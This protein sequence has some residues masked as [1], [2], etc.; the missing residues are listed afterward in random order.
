MFINS[1]IILSPQYYGLSCIKIFILIAKAENRRAPK[2]VPIWKWL[3][4][5]IQRFG[6]HHFD[7][8]SR[9]VHSIKNIWSFIRTGDRGLGFQLAEQ[10]FES[11]SRFLQNSLV[12]FRVIR[13]APYH[14]DPVQSRLSVLYASQVL[15]LLLGWKEVLHRQCGAGCFQTYGCT[16]WSTGLDFSLV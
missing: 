10:V 4:V 7:S 16:S 6:P 8:V 13:V 9:R 1:K 11:L 2:W 12:H 3:K 5:F 15:V 14:I